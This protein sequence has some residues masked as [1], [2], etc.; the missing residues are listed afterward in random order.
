MEKGHTSIFAFIGH[1]KWK[2]HRA[3]ERAK[4]LKHLPCRPKDMN[5][6]LRTYVLKRMSIVACACNP[7]TRE[8]ETGSLASQPSVLREV[9]ASGDSVSQGNIGEVWG[10]T[11][12]AVLWPP[13]AYAHTDTH[14]H[15]A[16][17]NIH[18]HLHIHVT[19]LPVLS[20]PSLR[21]KFLITKVPVAVYDGPW[22]KT[23]HFF[24]HAV[25]SP[26]TPN[27]ETCL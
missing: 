18:A 23:A 20:I 13:N 19:D 26:G 8:M 17:T 25:P 27:G 4:L 10:M 24:T 9:Q 16:H 11:P 22:P 14:A 15:L 7:S 6:N 1:V 12:E 5:R 21:S 3:K 2:H